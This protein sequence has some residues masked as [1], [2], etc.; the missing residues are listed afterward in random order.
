[1]EVSYELHA[2]ASLPLG[3]DPRYLTIRRQNLPQD[4]FRIYEDKISFPC[5]E[6]NSDPS[7]VKP[8]AQLFYRLSYPGYWK[9][10]LKC[11]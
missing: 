10:V 11:N 2:T 3:R 7:I 1:M 6:S 4:R 9:D 8:I 5:K